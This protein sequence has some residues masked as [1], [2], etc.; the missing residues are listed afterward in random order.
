MKSNENYE[1]DEKR[2][3]IMK[4]NEN[5]GELMQNWRRTGKELMKNRW[6]TSPALRFGSFINFVFVFVFVCVFVFATVKCNVIFLF[7][8]IYLFN[9]DLLGQVI[10]IWGEF[11]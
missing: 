9:T 6:R 2:L 1:N 7:V 4:N 8:Y 3:R 11:Y 10:D 5:D